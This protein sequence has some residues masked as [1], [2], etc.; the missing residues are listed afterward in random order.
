MAEVSSVDA[1]RQAAAHQSRRRDRQQLG[2]L[3][4]QCVANRGDKAR[5]LVEL[6]ERCVLGL[7]RR[8]DGF[9][10]LP[11]LGLRVATGAELGEQQGAQPREDER[12]HNRADD[13]DHE[14]PS[15]LRQCAQPRR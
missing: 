6:A 10:L 8:R 2:A 12:D 5:S 3:Q 7:Q 11:Q 1:L 15:H 4:A 13:G 14:T 9:G